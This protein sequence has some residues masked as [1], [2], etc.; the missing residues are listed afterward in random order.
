[1][2]NPSFTRDEAILLLDTYYSSNKNRLPEKSDEILSLSRLLKSLPIHFEEFK[3][4]PT[5]RSNSGIAQQLSGF[6]R[7]CI[8]GEKDP[9]VGKIFFEVAYEYEDRIS[10]LHRVADAIRRNRGHYNVP[11]GSDME[12]YGFPEGV[13][14][15][16]L[17]HIIEN[18]AA[19]TIDKDTKCAVC[20]LNPGLVYN[21]ERNYLELHL[22]IPPEDL[23][24]NI[25]YGKE[26]FLTVCPTCHKALHCIRPWCNKDDYLKVLR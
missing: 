8:R 24:A 19:K 21:T 4:T 20:S 23:D 26:K 18:K 5:F 1:M 6:L 2:A 16:H 14:L 9:N 22:L 25:K 15:G 11:F 10:L 7:S 12:D 13:L 17:H 3:E